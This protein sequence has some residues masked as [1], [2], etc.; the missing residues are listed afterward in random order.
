MQP[1]NVGIIGAGNVSSQYLNAAK[2]FPSFQ[3]TALADIDLAR[4]KARA[5]EYGV[6]KASSVEDLLADDPRGRQV[7]LQ[8]KTARHGARGSRTLT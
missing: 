7:G 2:F 6:A 1:I 8:R 4:A 5:E 3:I